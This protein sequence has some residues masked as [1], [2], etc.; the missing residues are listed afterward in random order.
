MSHKRSITIVVQAKSWNQCE[1]DD[2]TN[3]LQ[4]AKVF[5]NRFVF[6]MEF[7]LNEFLRYLIEPE[8][9]SRGSKEYKPNTLHSFFGLITLGADKDDKP[10]GDNHVNEIRYHKLHYDPF[11]IFFPKFVQEEADKLG[12]EDRVALAFSQDSNKVSKCFA[13]LA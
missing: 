6:E 12:F 1:A 13:F 11:L 3:I 10:L 9:K 7:H 2:V 5:H 4:A 8:N